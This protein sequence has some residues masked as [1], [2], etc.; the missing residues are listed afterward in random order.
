MHLAKQTTVR[1][2]AS[3]R[4]LALNGFPLGE[5]R[6][7]LQRISECRALRYKSSRFLFFLPFRTANAKLSSPR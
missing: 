4:L 7:A 1:L 6:S 5:K 3:I 2:I